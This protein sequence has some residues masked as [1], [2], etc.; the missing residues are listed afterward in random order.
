V[1]AERI[2]VA[3]ANPAALRE[4][5]ALEHYLTPMRPLLAD[6]EVTELCINRPGEALLERHSGWERVPLPIASLEWC[7]HLARLVASSTSQRI[8]QESPLLSA[9]LPSGERM[10]VVLPPACATGTVAIT[11]RRPSDRTWTLSELAAGGLFANCRMAGE[12]DDKCDAALAELLKAGEW[13]AFLRA[14]VRAKKNIIVSGATGSGKT[15]LTKAL[16]LKIPTEERLITIEDA[17]ELKLDGHPNSVRLF[18][19]KDEQGLAR[20]T[21]KKLLEACLRMRPDR[22]ILAELR[23]EEAYYYLRNVNSGHPGSITSVHASSAEGALEQL[24][25]LVKE[26]PAGREMG[27]GEIGALLDQ[28]VDVVV[29]CSPERFKRGV[30]SVWWR[31]LQL[32][33]A[34]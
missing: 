7:H 20:V 33:V 23:G 27:P 17:A 26:S 25:L 31:A 24:T 12:R 21:P 15:T 10:Q 8:N 28:L 34:C 1:S 18:Y 16:L 30:R 3:A 4:R 5:S 9:A 14:A 22:I 13:E 32:R 6:P 11:I 29:Q 19:S 2:P